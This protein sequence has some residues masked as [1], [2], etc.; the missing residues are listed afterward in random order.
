MADNVLI[1]VGEAGS[2]KDT[3]ADAL[4]AR[5]G[6]EKIAQSA[7]LKDLVRG[8]F[9]FSEDQLYGP[10]ASRN[11]NDW[12][13][14]DLQ[15]GHWRIAEEAIR[16]DL[17]AGW[18]EGLVGELY[19]P[20]LHTALVAWFDE[21]QR[22]AAQEGG[23]SPRLA[24]QTLGTDYGR[25]HLGA[26]TWINRALATAA[27]SA[28]PLAIIVDGRFSDEVRKV[29]EVGGVSLRIRALE[30]RQNV[31][32]HASENLDAISPELIDITVINGFDGVER[33]TSVVTAH[34]V[35]AFPQLTDRRR[36]IP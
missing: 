24:L 18:L 20:K 14:T 10:S 15:S 12:R 23:L 13:Y 31:R 5:F 7:P 33:F 1:L 19:D 26:D 36:V 25:K 27:A 3:A 32:G 11:G 8:A 34:I 17:G 6:A 16:G 28:S 22:L 2:G 35:N 30:R 29:R 9:D 21:L 4:V